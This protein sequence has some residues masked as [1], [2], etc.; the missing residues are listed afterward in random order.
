MQ[1]RDVGRTGERVSVVGFGGIVVMDETPKAAG[2]YVGFAVDNGVNYFDVAPTYG[3]SEERLG[4]ALRP[5]RKDVFLS[6]KTAERG[7]EKARVE[8][9]SSLKRL[10]AGYFNLYQ[11]HAVNTLEEMETVLGKEGALQTFIQAKKEGLIKN[12]GFSSHSEETALKLLEEF[13][14]D[15]VLFPVNYNCWLKEGFGAALVEKAGKMGTAVLAIKALAEGEWEKGEKKNWAKCWYRPVDTFEKAS[16]ALRFTLSKPVTAA[17]SP[18][19]F[20]F[21]KWM[22]EAEKY[23]KPLLKEEEALL[24]TP[25][26]NPKPLFKK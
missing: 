20:E 17:V 24:F 9:E 6:C 26:N 13:A 3:N 12:I 10:H 21:F 22:V 16:L 23:L 11:L 5:Y 1:K 14:F 15:T 4:A 8:L 19:H 7:K 2:E 18:G 25:G